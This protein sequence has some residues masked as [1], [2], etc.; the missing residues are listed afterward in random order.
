MLKPIP[1]R[2]EHFEDAAVLVSN[3]YR[4]LCEQDVGLHQYLQP[5][6]PRFNKGSTP[7]SE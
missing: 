6:N 4:R 7:Q 2:E 3:R 1:F 5:V